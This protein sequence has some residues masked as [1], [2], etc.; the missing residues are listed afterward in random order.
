MQLYYRKPIGIIYQHNPQLNP[1]LKELFRRGIDIDILDPS[2]CAFDPALTELS[3]SLLFND[4]SLPPYFKR[5]N[6]ALNQAIEYVR[7]VESLNPSARIING[8]RAS[9][10]LCNR[11]RQLSLFARLKIPFP[12]TRIVS[13]SDQLLAAANELKFPILLKSNQV[14]DPVSALV[15]EN[16]SDLIVALVNNKVAVASGKATVIQELVPAKGN[17]TIRAEIVNGKVLY[18]FR[19]YHVL[20]PGR[21]PLEVKAES[22]TPSPEIIRVIENITR[23]SLIDI[24]SIEYVMHKES[25]AILFTELRPHTSV[26]NITIEGL[27]INPIEQLANYIERRHQK[28]REIALAI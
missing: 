9:E 17:Y 21:V 13:S 3:Y 28:V 4:L 19:I 27:Q 10:I 20:R 7:H 8:S 23:A 24:G 14:D 18:A 15:F 5:K 12:R 1:V 11:T 16:V 2:D 25:N 26:F 22:V 6:S